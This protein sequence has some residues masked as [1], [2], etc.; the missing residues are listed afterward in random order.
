MFIANTE[1]QIFI[2]AKTG[3]DNKKKHFTLDYGILSWSL[4]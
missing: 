1:Q 4:H 2:E 3:G